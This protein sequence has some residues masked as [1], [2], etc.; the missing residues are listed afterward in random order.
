[1]QKKFEAASS[2]I[3]TPLN[4]I[5]I[6]SWFIHLNEKGDF[7]NGKG[8]DELVR[9]VNNNK[10][11]DIILF[12]HGWN[13]DLETARD[14][15]TN[16]M[17]EWQR[18]R[19]YLQNDRVFLFIGFIWPSV[20][21][22][23]FKFTNVHSFDDSIL[24]EEDMFDFISELKSNLIDSSKIEDVKRLL[25]Q[26]SLSEDEALSLFDIS[27][28]VFHD[29]NS[30]DFSCEEPL[31]TAQELLY[32]LKEVYDQVY[33]EKLAMKYSP[34][35]ILRIFSVWKMKDRSGIVGSNGVSI[36]LNELLKI[37]KELKI[38]LVGHS[39]GCKVMLSAI[40]VNDK[41]L[42]PVT[43][44]LLLQPAVSY[45]CFSKEDIVKGVKGSY[46]N[47][48]ANVESPIFTTFSKLDKP[49][50]LFYHIALIRNK[51]IGN[52]YGLPNIYSAMGGYGP[53]KAS[54]KLVEKLPEFGSDYILT[55]GVKVYGFDGSNKQIEDHG[56]V[57]KKEAAW[58]LILLMQ[59]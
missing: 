29:T 36:V 44:L 11:T 23:D 8:F 32:I 45:L 59:Q 15:Y 14:L 43:S 6:D 2:T 20:W 35:D 9:D 33:N 58:L 46:R 38:H 4:G 52:L 48:S 51:D 12:S 39:F 34:I 47:T 13:N 1:M 40:L 42:R 26:G 25:Y 21:F 54:E 49:L 3:K 5:S 16:F 56:D 18:G 55:D 17:T 22:K 30:S 7:I 10:V 27:L 57:T 53:S 28:K 50:H 37:N 19:G 31:V 41:P 24:S